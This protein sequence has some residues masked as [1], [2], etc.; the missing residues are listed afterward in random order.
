MRRIDELH[1]EYPFVGNRMLRDMLKG[2]GHPIG[3][4]HVTT[5]KNEVDSCSGSFQGFEGD[6]VSP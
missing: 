4:K 3:R 1:L 5:I 6:M 2:E